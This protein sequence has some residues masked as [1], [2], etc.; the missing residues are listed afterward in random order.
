MNFEGRDNVHTHIGVIFS[1]IIMLCVGCYSVIKLIFLIIK[2]NPNI[3]TFTE[4][5]VFDSE[6]TA[7]ELADQNFHMAFA[8]RDYKT[9]EYKSDP[10]YVTWRV[11][12]FEGDG[13]TK[14][15]NFKSRS[16]Q[17]E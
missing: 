12:V 6:A 13:S 9:N 17:R 14:S 11:D 15:W 1:F 8:V 16:L 4:Y 5:D 3:S 7:I 2:H 10:R